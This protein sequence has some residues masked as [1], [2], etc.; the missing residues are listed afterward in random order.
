MIKKKLKNKICK[1]TYSYSYSGSKVP[2]A[3][4]KFLFFLISTYQ[5][6]EY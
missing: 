5:Y 6:I 1:A 3:D 4:G 2:K